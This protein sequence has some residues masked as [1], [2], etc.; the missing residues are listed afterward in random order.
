VA[1]S[2]SRSIAVRIAV[3]LLILVIVAL[4][5]Y[6]SEMWTR[7]GNW[8]GQLGT[9][10]PILFVPVGALMMSLLIPKTAI[11]V[12][13]GLLFGSVIGSLVLTSTAIL[14][15]W[16][17]F[18]LGR[19]W[20]HS[21]IRERK[22]NAWCL[23]RELAGEAGFFTHL[24]FRLAPIPTSFISYSMGASG[25]RFKPY[26]LAA[27]V[28]SFPQW[29][30]VFCGAATGLVLSGNAR[31]SE[32]EAAGWVSLMVSAAG[33]VAL[34]LFLPKMASVR[35]KEIRRQRDFETSFHQA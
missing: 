7:I 10:G 2:P 4:L 25:A 24:M 18:Y 28:G 30:W 31:S 20:L 21:W 26:L 15:A 19:W 14:A 6:Q 12:Y 1:L 13:A 16:L 29:M 23:V 34:T 3:P 33:A 9:V 35:L 8:V 32:S 27:I 17:N 11:S 5:V 22:E